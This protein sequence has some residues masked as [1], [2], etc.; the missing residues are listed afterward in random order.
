MKQMRLEYQR[1]GAGELAF[2][3]VSAPFLVWDGS[4]C[5]KMLRKP[6]EEMSA[7][8]PRPDA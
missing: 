3:P 1:E 8:I 6:A 5:C 2:F 4:I 7:R